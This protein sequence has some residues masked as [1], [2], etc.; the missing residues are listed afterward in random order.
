M[1]RSEKQG[2][3]KKKLRKSSSNLTSRRGTGVSAS[4]GMAIP[5][6]GSGS[7]S[8]ST[9]A[10]AGSLGIGGGTS[11]HPGP[12]LWPATSL[13]GSFMVDASPSSSEWYDS[14]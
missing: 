2:V 10:P 7:A 5:V 12:S 8:A 1:D 13:G 14:L 3:Q 9:G 6:D 11:P 4:L